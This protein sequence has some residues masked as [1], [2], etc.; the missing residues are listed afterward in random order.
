MI[1]FAAGFNMRREEFFKNIVNIAKFGIFGSLFTWFLFVGMFWLLFEYVDM[2]ETL[3]ADP[4][5][6]TKTYMT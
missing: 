2:G 6:A 3:V 4:H 1:L 5:D